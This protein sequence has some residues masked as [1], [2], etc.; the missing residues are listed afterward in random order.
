M[1]IGEDK[2]PL[3]TPHFP[4]PRFPLPCRYLPPS[5]PLLLN[6]ASAFQAYARL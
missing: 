2:F 6:R 5:K 1:T 4:L 3:P